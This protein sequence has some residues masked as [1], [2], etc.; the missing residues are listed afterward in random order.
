MNSRYSAASSPQH[1]QHVSA[2]SLP[3]TVNTV[4]GAPNLSPSPASNVWPATTVGRPDAPTILSVAGSK[5]A[6]KLVVRQAEDRSAS[7]FVLKT[8]D[9]S[10]T[11]ISP[12]YAAPL[13]SVG[14]PDSERRQL[15][16]FA[17]DDSRRG[18]TYRFKVRQAGWQVTKCFCWFSA[19]PFMHAFQLRGSLNNHTHLWTPDTIAPL[20]RW[21]LSTLWE[22]AQPPT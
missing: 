1:P 16:V 5:D 22:R 3:L 11:E 21:C 6:I 17:T 19:C 2:P 7:A 14:A 18:G 9:P 13:V 15:V 4:G 8:F 20:C 10:G 12:A